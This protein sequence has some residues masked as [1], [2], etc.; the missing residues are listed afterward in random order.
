[1][2]LCLM[3]G[4]TTT[5]LKYMTTGMALDIINDYFDK[6]NASHTQNEEPEVR[7]A[8]QADFDAF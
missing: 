4:L 6:K 3:V 5:D 8:T 1:M 2:S 7:E